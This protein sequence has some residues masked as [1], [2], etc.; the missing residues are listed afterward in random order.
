MKKIYLGVIGLVSVVFLFVWCNDSGIQKGDGEAID[1][2]NSFITNTPN[3]GGGDNG[4]GG[5]TMPSHVHDWGNWVVTTPATCEATGIETRTC[6]LGDTSETKTIPKLSEDEC[7]PFGGDWK[8]VES[9]CANNKIQV[10]SL[11]G[12]GAAVLTS[13]DGETVNGSWSA[14]G[15]TFSLY[16]SCDYFNEVN[17]CWQCANNTVEFTFQL[18][19][20][21]NNRRLTLN[22]DT[23]KR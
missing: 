18:T 12:N 21:G 5:N 14:A 15:Y 3:N 13:I 16:V 17:P 9:S 22:G 2:L 19:G 1:F 11:N 20:S 6:T 10:L 4:G 8:I 23:W 7:D